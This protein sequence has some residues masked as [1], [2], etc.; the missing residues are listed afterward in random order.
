MPYAT[1]RDGTPLHYRVHDCTDPWRKPPTLILQ[2]GFSRTSKFWFGMVP[3]LMRYYRVVCPDLRGQGESGTDFDNDKLAHVSTYLEDFISIIDHLGEEKVHY[4]GESLGGMLSYHFAIQHPDRLRSI[5]PI[6]APLKVEVPSREHFPYFGFPTW[7]EALETMGVEAW[8]RAANAA[9]R[10]PPDADP[11]LVEWF[12]QESSKAP[13]DVLIGISRVIESID[14]KALLPQ[15]KVPV[16]GL[17]PQ[18]SKMVSDAQLALLRQVPDIQI[19]KLAIPWHMIW[20]LAPA[21]CARHMLY[22]MAHLDGI[23]CSE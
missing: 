18:G 10:F 13:I 15:V 5:C 7:K 20:A 19:V 8:S 4:A 12:V 17:Y 2:A 21:S 23:D 22:F 16:L 9:T 14:V 11:G 6:S 3:H 1:A